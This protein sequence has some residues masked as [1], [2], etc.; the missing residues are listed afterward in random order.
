M[1]AMPRLTG[2]DGPVRDRT[3]NMTGIDPPS[4]ELCVLRGSEVP[5]DP[6]LSV[7]ILVL[8]RPQLALDCLDALRRP[9]GCPAG[10]ELM[11]VANGT[12]PDE[13]DRLADRQDIVLVS[14]QDN[15][16]FAGGCNQAVSL[17]R[18]PQIV[19]LNDDSR[20]E[21]GCL[22]ALVRAA[23]NE[24]A[25]GA[26]GSRITSTDGTLEEAGSVIWRDGSCAHVGQG[27]SP[28]NDAYQEPRDVDYASANGLLVTRGAWDAV[29]GFDERYFPAYY[30][31]VDLCLM[32]AQHG[33]RI[34]YEPQAR[35][36]HLGSQ[37]TSRLYREFLMARNQ[38]KL[39]E[40]WGPALDRFEPPPRTYFG[41]EFEATMERALNRV[42]TGTSPP[43][44]DGS[45]ACQ[46][47]P[48]DPT[49]AAERL[50]AEYLSYLE[51]R[52]DRQDR[53]ITY[54]EMY[55]RRLWSVRLRR[56]VARRLAQ[57]RH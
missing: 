30:E 42:V 23:E 52:A 34:R 40:K 43:R 28:S 55:V 14:N 13:L 33:F 27:L 25:T 51:Q 2:R 22:D 32:L 20:V 8:E 11:V 18:A 4:S 29:G 53:R 41:P 15:L 10:T 37:S 47:A 56:W 57:L 5:D 17:A 3:K 19:F 39:V 44:P 26:V 12:P 24:P 45:R 49:E 31:D 36:V 50:P 46:P 48:T 6:V 54:L 1:E 35:L 38:Q 7:C 9:G 21:E 16:G